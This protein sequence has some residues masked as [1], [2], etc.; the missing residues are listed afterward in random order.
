MP[1]QRW[2]VL[3]ISGCVAIGLAA[4]SG[5]GSSP[6]SPSASPSPGATTIRGTAFAGDGT[7]VSGQRTALSTPTAGALDSHLTAHRC[8]VLATSP[9]R[10]RTVVAR[11][12]VGGD[13]E[14]PRTEPVAVIGAQRV[15]R[16]PRFLERDR[17]D[18]V[19]DIGRPGAALRERM[20]I[21]GVSAKERGEGMIVTGERAGHEHTVIGWFVARRRGGRR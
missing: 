20:H 3:G 16:P 5:N 4:C 9:P 15:E 2:A 10:A 18:V 7:T 8:E 1:V 21:G 17:D 6:T 19:G 11:H 14:H 13:P 12:L